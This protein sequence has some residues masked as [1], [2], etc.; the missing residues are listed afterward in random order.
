MVPGQIFDART[1]IPNTLN[2]L[3]LRILEH[4]E[5][6]NPVYSIAKIIHSSSFEHAKYYGL[7]RQQYSSLES[8]GVS[9]EEELEKWWPIVNARHIEHAVSEL[10]RRG[11]IIEDDSVSQNLDEYD[12]YRVGSRP[13]SP[14]EKTPIPPEI[15]FYIIS[16]KVR[17]PPH[18]TGPMLSLALS[19]LNRLPAELKGGLII[20]SMFHLAKFNAVL[21][22]QLLTSHFLQL[23]FAPKHH[24]SDVGARNAK[25]HFNL[26][27]QAIARNPVHSIQAASSTV[28]L[29]KAM[30]SRKLGLWEESYEELVKD[31]F[32]VL[33]LTNWLRDRAVREGYIPRTGQL[34]EYV[35]LFTGP[36]PAIENDEDYQKALEEL[37]QDKGFFTAGEGKEDRLSAIRF[38]EGLVDS[39]RRATPVILPN[40]P[41]RVIEKASAHPLFSAVTPAP[42]P[43]W[44]YA[45]TKPFQ[46]LSQHLQSEWLMGFRKAIQDT[47]QFSARDIVS[48]FEWAIPS[49]SSNV[50]Q[51]KFRVRPTLSLYT[52]LIR[53]LLVR[54]ERSTTHPISGTDNKSSSQ[55]NGAFL[56][57]EQY[58]SHLRSMGYPLDSH[59]V[60]VGLEALTRVGKPH[61]AFA[62]LNDY[63][64]I[65]PTAATGTGDNE[66]KENLKAIFPNVR[67]SAIA[68]NDFLVALARIGRYDCVFWLFQHSVK[69]YGVWPDSRALS[70]L[71]QSARKAQRVDGEI[72][73]GWKGFLRFLRK[74]QADRRDQ[75]PSEEEGKYVGLTNEEVATVKILRSMED[76][77]GSIDDL[78]PYKP[79]RLWDG[80]LPIQ[81]AQRIFWSCVLGQAWAKG[82]ATAA[83]DQDEGDRRVDIARGK[84]AVD[85]LLAMPSPAQPFVRGREPI[86]DSL[87]IPFPSRNHGNGITFAEL[88][89]SRHLDTHNLP[90]YPQV[91]LQ[92]THFRDYLLLLG[93]AP[94]ERPLFS[95]STSSH[96]TDTETRAFVPPIKEVP[97][98][99]A[100]QR[101]LRIPP[102]RDT[103]AASITLFGEYGGDGDIPPLV[104]EFRRW[105]GRRAE[106]AQAEE[107]ELTFGWG[108][109]GEYAKFVHW[110]ED[111]VDEVEID[112][113]VPGKGL[114]KKRSTMP[115]SGIFTK[116]R[117]II[118]KMRE[119]T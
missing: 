40:D 4:K 110:M 82:V 94:Q 2:R 48:F 77:V 101:Y 15:L 47:S 30:D 41:I 55:T 69:L 59:A 16:Y 11:Y 95:A 44:F 115:D 42:L 6:R 96:G 12:S 8:K 72:S 87:S 116:W 54:G 117:K 38:L 21:P 93:L 68:F 114:A 58:F 71:L 18:A 60:A 56:L 86:F 50:R 79:G 111:W 63:C 84:E 33:E 75:Q 98:V 91:V 62:L 27:L 24:A 73:G 92:D 36:K 3:Q 104:D 76:I 105:R 107:D 53:A 89:R 90:S 57:A 31:R 51:R 103:L 17:A 49:S 61:K 108:P 39:S 112:H 65:V 19:Y 20:M 106:S 97:L 10:R 7:S 64:L 37:R 83:Q 23:D 52:E 35:K 13:S 29:L 85:D 5:T 1:A 109:N 28:A 113:G 9:E 22:M 119:G 81:R 102:S 67:L 88:L 99:L 25:I 78:I 34:E 46:S 26:L 74:R 32:V 43:D 45:P 118:L 66:G 70:V 80:E 14:S 100:W